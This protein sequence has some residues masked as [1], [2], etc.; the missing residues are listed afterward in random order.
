MAF[1]IQLTWLLHNVC[2]KIIDRK[3]MKKIWSATFETIE[4]DIIFTTKFA[5]S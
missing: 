3:K 1:T 4:T 5:S 2:H